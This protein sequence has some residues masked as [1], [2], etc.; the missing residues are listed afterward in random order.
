M[1]QSRAKNKGTSSGARVVTH[2][3]VLK[4]T[5]IILSVYNKSETDSISEDEIGDRLA[6][7]DV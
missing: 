2:L 3:K 6:S 1:Q 5:V 4:E 7:A